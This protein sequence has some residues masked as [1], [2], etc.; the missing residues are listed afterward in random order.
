MAKKRLSKISIMH[1]TRLVLR[2]ALLIAAVI[3]YA[4]NRARGTGKPFGAIGENFFVVGGVWLL[5]VLEMV[6]RFFPARFES[7]G[8]QKQ[9]GRNYRAKEENGEK[10]RPQKPAWWCTFLSAAFWFMLNGAFGVLY[11]TGIFDEGILVLISLAYAV[12]DMICVLFFCPFQTWIMRNKCCTSCRIYNWDYAMMFTPLI[13]FKSFWGWSILGISLLLL[14]EWEL[15][16]RLHPERFTENTNCSLSCANCKEKLCHHKRQLRG[17]LKA[18]KS[19]ERNA[20][21]QKREELK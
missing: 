8:C 11:Y 20:K 12:C 4:V 3:L 1:F 15:L 19:R 2:S 5:F 17:F 6:F 13:F 14:L 16:Y 18:K 21:N 7:M 9:F 10:L